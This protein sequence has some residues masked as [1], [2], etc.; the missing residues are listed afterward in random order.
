MGR[1]KGRSAL[2]LLSGSG[3]GALT[4]LRTYGESLS[5]LLVDKMLPEVAVAELMRAAQVVSPDVDVII[6]PLSAYELEAANDTASE[7]ENDFDELVRTILAI[8]VR[9]NVH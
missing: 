3:S 7:R 4:M 1:T 9:A 6:A 5:V 2:P 8:A